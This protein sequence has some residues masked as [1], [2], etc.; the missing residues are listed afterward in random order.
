MI[1]YFYLSV[2]FHFKDP[3]VSD[4]KVVI[5]LIDSIKPGT[6]NYDLVKEGSNDEVRKAVMRDLQLE[7]IDSLLEKL[8]SLMS[9]E[10]LLVYFDQISVETV[11]LTLK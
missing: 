7:P 3:S 6:I 1:S 9:I 8:I 2:S 11:L 5:D 10:V 4:A